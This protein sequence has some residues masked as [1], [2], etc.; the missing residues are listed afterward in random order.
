MFPVTTAGRLAAAVLMLLGIGFISF[1]T[2]SVAAHFVENEEGNVGDEVQRLHERL[3]RIES[4]LREQTALAGRDN[5]G[6]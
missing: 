2:A 6:V 5:E 1:I 3:D 4:T